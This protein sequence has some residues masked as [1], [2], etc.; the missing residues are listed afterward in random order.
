M[1]QVDQAI[2]TSARTDQRD[3]YHLVSRSDGISEPDALALSQWCPSHDSLISENVGTSCTSFFR[4]PSGASCVSVTSSAGAEYSGR[5]GPKIYT[6]C[7]VARAETMTQFA[8]NPLALLRAVK[9]VGQLRILSNP[10]TRLACLDLVGRARSLDQASIAPLLKSPG[11]RWLTAMAAA[12]QNEHRWITLSRHRAEKVVAGLLNCLPPAMRLKFTFTTGLRYSRRRPFQMTWLGADHSTARRLSRTEDLRVLDLD[13]PPPGDLLPRTGP[14]A[15]LATILQSGRVSQIATLHGTVQDQNLEEETPLRDALLT[16]TDPG[17]NVN[18]NRAMSQAAETNMP[19]APPT[20]GS[21]GSARINLAALCA[22]L[23]SD[24]DN[25][26]IWLAWQQAHQQ[27]LAQHDYDTAGELVLKA[28][29][30]FGIVSRPPTSHLERVCELMRDQAINDP[31]LLRMSRK[32][33]QGMAAVFKPQRWVTLAETAGRL[34]L[35]TQPRGTP[36]HETSP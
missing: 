9:A 16:T 31:E 10:P 13:G 4:L 3:G 6:Q 27:C 17:N 23:R 5:R 15:R 30:V 32:R 29:Q 33:L 25:D 2:F 18:T 34:A 35:A 12:A 8:N 22:S 14:L 19:V 24:P 1:G 26:S 21:R 20:G 11:A 28:C 7:L 36:H